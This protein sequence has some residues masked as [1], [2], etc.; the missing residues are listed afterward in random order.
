MPTLKIKVE[1]EHQ[2]Y[3]PKGWTIVKHKDGYVLLAKETNEYIEIVSIHEDDVEDAEFQ[4]FKT[5]ILFKHELIALSKKYILPFIK[6]N[7]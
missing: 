7:R 5:T 6:K 1:V 4:D 3:A 2:I